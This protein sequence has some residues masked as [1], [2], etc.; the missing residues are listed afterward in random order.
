MQRNGKLKKNPFVVKIRN[1]LRCYGENRK[2]SFNS[3]Y[4]PSKNE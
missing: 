4:I 1:L 3:W 2:L